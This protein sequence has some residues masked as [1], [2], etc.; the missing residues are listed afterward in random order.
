MR[1]QPKY[2]RW[3]TMSGVERRNAKM[4]RLFDDYFRQQREQAAATLYAVSIA[5]IYPDCE[6]PVLVTAA[7]T[8]T[9]R[10]ADGVI[11]VPAEWQ[12]AAESLFDGD[13][14]KVNLETGEWVYP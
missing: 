6:L 10:F 5:S 4:H 9:N 3:R 7:G 13:H 11:G 12:E 14:A 2:P 1:K 8:A